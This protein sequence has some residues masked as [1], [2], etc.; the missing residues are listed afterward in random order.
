MQA[1]TQRYQLSTAVIRLFSKLW[2]RIPYFDRHVLD[3]VPCRAAMLNILIISMIY[4]VL[5]H[6][7]NWSENVA[8]LVKDA[9]LSKSLNTLTSMHFFLPPS[10]LRYTIQHIKRGRRCCTVFN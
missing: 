6:G 9:D 2:G 1:V 10:L 4:L 3:K 7:L 5:Q 8:R